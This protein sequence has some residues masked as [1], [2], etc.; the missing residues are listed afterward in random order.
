MISCQNIFTC[1]N[2]C[3]CRCLDILHKFIFTNEKDFI[4]NTSNN[5][6]TYFDFVFWV[7]C[8]CNNTKFYMHKN[9]VMWEKRGLGK[10]SLYRRGFIRMSVLVSKLILKHTLKLWSSPKYP[11]STMKKLPPP[12]PHTIDC[13]LTSYLAKESC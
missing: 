8:F 9:I 10:F 5:L 12:C 11:S 3:K 2:F 13:C 1:T 7:I 4:W 6:K